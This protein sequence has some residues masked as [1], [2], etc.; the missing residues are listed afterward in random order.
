[1]TVPSKSSFELFL[2]R[3]AIKLHFSGSKWA[4][5]S[6]APQIT[7]GRLCPTGDHIT[8]E[9][10][11]VTTTPFT[12]MGKTLPT[13]LPDDYRLMEQR[14]EKTVLVCWFTICYSTKSDGGGV[15]VTWLLYEGQNLRCP[16]IS[17]LG[18]LAK[19]VRMLWQQKRQAVGMIWYDLWPKMFSPR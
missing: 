4:P 17:F 3:P 1:M 13:W 6:P 12:D 16:T 11:S 14:D 10:Y 2:W 8:P 18:R 7:I 19:Y 5:Y 15:S 9:F